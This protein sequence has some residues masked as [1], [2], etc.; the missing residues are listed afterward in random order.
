[1]SSSC[2][3]PA[4]FWLLVCGVASAVSGLWLGVSRLSVGAENIVPTVNAVNTG[5]NPAVVNTATIAAPVKPPLPGPIPAYTTPPNAATPANIPANIVATPAPGTLPTSPVAG[6]PAKQSP[7]HGKTPAAPSLADDLSAGKLFICGGGILPPPVLEKFV[8]LAGGTAARIVYIPTASVYAGTPEL[9]ARLSFWREQQAAAKLKS[10]D[11]LHAE[12]REAAEQPSAIDLL[13][14]ATAVW[15]GGGVQTRITERYLNTS[16]EREV[17]QLLKRGGLVGGTSAGAAIMSDP[18]ISGGM[19]VPSL[20][21]GFGFLKN[22]VVD[23]H[24]IKRNRHHRLAQALKHD[25]QRVG[26]GIDEGTALIVSGEKLEVVGESSVVVC[27]TSAVEPPSFQELPSGANANLGQFL[28]KA[29]ELNPTQV[30][31]QPSAERG[32]EKAVAVDRPAVIQKV[33]AETVTPR[34]PTAAGR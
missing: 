9:E 21:P 26:L 6:S 3:S 12:S 19:P 33:S 28:A 27:V 18:M 16:V 17:K 2:K 23:Q 24:F 29:R 13:K 22:T 20:A 7:P 31:Q 10:F 4:K 15:F 1:M 8:E 11:V 5:A 25:P 34:E 32:V 30:A 14:N